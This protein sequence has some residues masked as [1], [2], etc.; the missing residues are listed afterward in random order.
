MPVIRVGDEG[1]LAVVEYTRKYV[2]CIVSVLSMVA[3]A[4]LI[5]LLGP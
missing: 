3:K 2:G 1:E 5:V 4:V